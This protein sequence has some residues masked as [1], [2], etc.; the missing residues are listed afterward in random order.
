MS[1]KVELVNL[2]LGR[3]TVEEALRKM[4]NALST[5]KRQGVKAVILIHGYGSSGEGGGAIKLAA[6]K[7]LGEPIMRGIVRA[8]VEGESWSLK[9]R[10][11]I[12]MCKAL[13]NEERQTNGNE[14]V[15]VVILR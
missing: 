12:G 3:P 1:K 10:E 5:H 11:F 6:R 8:F 13:E 4:S 15:T 9:K 14:G 2:E 7:T